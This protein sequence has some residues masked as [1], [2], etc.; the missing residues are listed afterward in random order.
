M[1]VV[2][3]N[4]EWDV[5]WWLTWYKVS[6]NGLY[7]YSAFLVFW[8]LKALY[9][10]CQHSPIHTH[11]HTLRAG[12]LSHTFTLQ[13]R[14]HWEWFGVQY[15][16]Q[17]HADRRS[18]GL[19]HPPSEWQTARSTYW[20]TAAPQCTSNLFLAVWLNFRGWFSFSAHVITIG[21]LFLIRIKQQRVS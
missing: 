6:V 7:L 8:L 4:S 13:W 21:R 14:S 9:N 1:C 10:T 19:N 12:T 17:G 11:I 3:L 5:R 2:N 20:T 16:A 18:R 15:L